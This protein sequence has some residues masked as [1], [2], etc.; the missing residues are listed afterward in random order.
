MWLLELNRSPG[1]A[2]NSAAVEASVMEPLYNDL[3]SL[4]IIP[5]VSGAEPVAGGFDQLSVAG[6]SQFPAA[7][8]GKLSK[9]SLRLFERKTKKKM[10]SD[11]TSTC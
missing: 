7:T 8:D 3:F 6:V 11:V 4:C 10:L 9:L 5:S 2:T 1:I